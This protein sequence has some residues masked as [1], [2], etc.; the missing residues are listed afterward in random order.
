MELDTFT[1]TQY[2]TSDPASFAWTSARERWPIILTQG[3][4]D[5]H[6][7]TSASSDEAAVKEGK[8]IVSELAKL[9][10]ELQH[11]RDMA[12]IPDDGEGDVETYNKELAARGGLKWHSAPWLYAECQLYRYA[13][14]IPV[15]VAVPVRVPVRV[16]VPADGQQNAVDRP[17]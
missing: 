3:I 1:A 15:A 8:Q 10:Y 2:N 13:V 6:K 5:V 14:P 17:R 11:N 9:K 16:P 12:P 7:S 4:D